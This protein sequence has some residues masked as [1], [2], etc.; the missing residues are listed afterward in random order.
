MSNENLYNFTNT[1]KFGSARKKNQLN[2]IFDN[3][4]PEVN[5]GAVLLEAGAGRG[6]F[7]EIARGHGYNY[8]GIEPSDSLRTDLEERGFRML[9]KSLPEIDLPE[10]SVDIVYSYDV[11]EHLGDYTTV[12]DFFVEAKKILKPGGHIIVMVP[13]A[14]TIGHL[15]YLYEY[16]HSFFTSIDRLQTMLSDAGFEITSSRA[17]LTELGLTKSKLN[18]GL[19]RVIANTVLLFARSIFLTSIMRAVLGRDLL[20]KIHKNLYD[21]VF[22]V[23]K[24]S[25]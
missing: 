12:L 5:D 11:V 14:E 16:Q 7:A 15:F 21:H 18:Q 8:I 6:E 23:A 3:I 10:A 19:D 1:T 9:H 25:N 24:K 13:N 4:L 2:M 20:F 22:V 17:F